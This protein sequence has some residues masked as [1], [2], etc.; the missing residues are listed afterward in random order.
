MLCSIS[1]SAALPSAWNSVLIAAAF[2][3]K[4]QAESDNCQASLALGALSVGGFE[5]IMLRVQTLLLFR[6]TACQGD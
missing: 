2:M 5:D 6:L 4:L 1:W 3:N